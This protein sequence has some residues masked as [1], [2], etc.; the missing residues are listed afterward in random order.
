MFTSDLCFGFIT[1]VLSCLCGYFIISPDSVDFQIGLLSPSR[2]LFLPSTFVH[3]FYRLLLL[4]LLC[5]PYAW[6]LLLWFLVMLLPCR[7][8][9]SEHATTLLSSE[10]MVRLLFF[11]VSL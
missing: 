8:L 3:R 10:R 4:P 7:P 9:Q 1:A 6:L 5:C 2:V 11:H